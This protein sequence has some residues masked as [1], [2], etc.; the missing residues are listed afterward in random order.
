MDFI[1]GITF[2]PFGRRGVLGTEKARK[3]LDYMAESTGADLVLFAPA[4]LQDTAQS[5]SICYTSERTFSDEELIGMIR[6]AKRRGLRVGLKPTVNCRNGVWRAYISF[7]E[8]DVVCEPKWS[9]WF[10]AYRDFQ[11]HY[12]RIAE[13][14]GCDLFIA[15]CEMVM[16]EHR[17]EEWRE[18]IRAI[19]GCYTG[20]VSY[21][22]DK[23]QEDHVA[24][25]DCVDLISSSGYYPAGK[26]EKEL[27]RI[28]QVVRRFQKPFFFA[29]AGCMSRAGSGQVPNNWALQGELRL[30]EQTEWYREMFQAC[31]ARDWVGG[32]CLW[33]WAPEIWNA[34]RAGRDSGYQICGKPVQSVIREFYGGGGPS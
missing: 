25:W 8:Q 7:F 30:E 2:A 18:V 26:W 31:R 20:P 15:G 29:E 33:E 11:T 1:K 28:E 24:W 21:N 32:Y 34:A 6:Y 14:E 27:D 17:E 10:A 22:T 9:R 13:A 19:R 3:S 5:E 16:S 12:A 4:G 23:Y